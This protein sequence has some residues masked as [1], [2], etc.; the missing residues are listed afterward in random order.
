MWVPDVYEGAPTPVTAF[1]AAAPKVAAL[2]LFIR[3]MHDAFPGIE[4]E[5]QQIVVFLAIA[6]MLLGAFG[7]IGQHN[8]KRLMAYSSIGHVGYALVGLAAASPE[9]TSGVL[10]YLASYLVMTL[11]TFAAILCM[12]RGDQMVE[13]IDELSGLARTNLPM[14]ALIAVLLFSLAGIPPMAGFFAKFYVF[15]PA[16]REGLYG[17]AVIG[18]VASVIGAYYYLRIV[19][20]MF[21]D[22]PAEP[23]QAAPGS[24]WLVLVLSALIVFPLYLVVLGPLVARAEAAARSLF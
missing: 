4:A 17:L 3:T 15:L 22:E 12:R 10:I 8:I 2:G 13:E 6:S 11:G 24:L 5:W 19:K 21:F 23:F 1:F 16:I 20:V 18:V 14:A 9:G 7:A